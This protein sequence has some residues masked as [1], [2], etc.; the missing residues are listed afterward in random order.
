AIEAS[1]PIP[2]PPP[3][4]AT[5]RARILVIDDEPLIGRAIRRIL[6]DHD[7]AVV[8]RA[9]DGLAHIRA[10][11]HVD[12]IVCDVMMPELSGMD[13]HAELARSAPAL[14]DRILFAT[15]GTFTPSAQHFLSRPDIRYI[16][17]PIDAKT[18]RDV[19]ARLLAE[20]PRT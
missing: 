20:H 9:I 10:G 19:V 14:L 2:A 11:E 7:V 12:L 15:G 18:L 16:D 3:T 6:K 4:V 5:R 8:H 13:V 17:K 1:P